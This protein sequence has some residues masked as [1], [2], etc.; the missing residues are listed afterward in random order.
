MGAFGALGAWTVCAGFGATVLAGAGE[1]ETDLDEDDG[2][3][4]EG[5]AETGVAVGPVGLLAPGF[6]AGRG[7]NLGG[8]IGALPWPRHTQAPSM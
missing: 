6:G 4:E 5:L 1:A 2:T 3:P 8:G 7:R